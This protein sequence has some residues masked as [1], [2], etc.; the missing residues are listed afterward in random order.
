MVEAQGGDVAYVDDPT[1]LPAA[2]IVR[3]VRAPRSGYLNQV[4]ARE[5][6]LAAVDLGAGRHKKTDLIDHAVGFVC[7]HKVGDRVQR[8]DLLFSVHANDEA[9]A[10]AAI[11]R[12]LAAHRVSP[13]R[14]R[15]LPLFYG[16]L[17]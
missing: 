6:G 5:I 13:K 1:R 7:P 4:D 14:V 2:R 16:T 11:V 8:G 9:R 10:E 17:R 12:V 15:K 3:A